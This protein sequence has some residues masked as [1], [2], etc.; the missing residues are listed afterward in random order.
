MGL[1]SSADEGDGAGSYFTEAA[2]REIGIEE[3]IKNWSDH[4]QNALQSD[5]LFL[6]KTHLPPRDDQPAIYVVRD[7]RKAIVSYS[8]FH[9]S[10]T[11]EPYPR[12]LDLVLGNDYCG[13]WSEHCQE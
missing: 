7:G 13:G 10:F 3:E 9:Q 2:R 1:S 5:E 12:I 4:Y 8:R 6:I 11:P